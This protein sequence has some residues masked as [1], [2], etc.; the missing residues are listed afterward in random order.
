MFFRSFKRLNFNLIFAI[1]C[2]SVFTGCVKDKSETATANEL[3][4]INSQAPSEKP[5]MIIK[6]IIGKN[7]LNH[8][9]YRS[10]MAPVR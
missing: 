7:I 5:N 8:H 4:A 10:R 2:L 6:V 1:A 9:S 3:Q